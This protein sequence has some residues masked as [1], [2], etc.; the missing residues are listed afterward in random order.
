MLAWPECKVDKNFSDERRMAWRNRCSH[1]SGWKA[2]T[3]M[4]T[5]KDLG[6]FEPEVTPSKPRT[7]KDE[8]G[9]VNGAPSV[10]A[11]VV[12]NQRAGRRCNYRIGHGPRI[13]RQ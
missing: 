7:E 1:A 4:S 8:N 5:S 13:R 12:V 9:P 3:V 11:P 10:S 2:Q 6:P